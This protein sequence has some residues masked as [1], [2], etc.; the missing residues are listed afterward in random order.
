[1]RLLLPNDNTLR[2]YDVN[3]FRA[4]SQAQ[5]IEFEHFVKHNGRFS[6]VITCRLNNLSVKQKSNNFLQ[7]P[8]LRAFK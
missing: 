4:I 2:R 6:F 8:C 3:F 7:I 1:M 5:T